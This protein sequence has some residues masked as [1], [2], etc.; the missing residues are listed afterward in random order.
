MGRTVFQALPC[1]IKLSAGQNI[2]Q[3]TGKPNKC[4]KFCRLYHPLFCKQGESGLL[5][6][7]ASFYFFSVTVLQFRMNLHNFDLKDKNI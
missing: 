4:K 5:L 1:F 2:R 3:V 7:R 6:I